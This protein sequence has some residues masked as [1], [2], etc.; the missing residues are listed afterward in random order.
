MIPNERLWLHLMTLAQT[1][2]A[3]TATFLPLRHLHLP[4]VRQPLLRSHKPNRKPKAKAA[5][6]KTWRASCHTL[7]IKASGYHLEWLA[8]V[9]H[10]DFSF[11][12]AI[13]RF[14]HSPGLTVSVLV[15]LVIL[16]SWHFAINSARNR[17]HSS[18]SIDSKTPTST[19]RSSASPHEFEVTSSDQSLTSLELQIP[20]ELRLRSLLYQ[21]S[22]P[23]ARLTSRAHFFR[24]R[25]TRR[26]TLSILKTQHSHLSP[27]RTPSSLYTSS[28][29]HSSTSSTRAKQKPIR[30]LDT[31][32]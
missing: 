21:C 17:R 3:A 22:A 2:T 32:C 23:I 26:N 10:F 1:A 4:L 30:C 11:V 20:L 8:P 7:M 29:V 5:R 15:A 25:L 28:Q 12:S 19:T 24:S 14:C 27:T 18:S 31:G 6:R 9:C 16:L 13:R